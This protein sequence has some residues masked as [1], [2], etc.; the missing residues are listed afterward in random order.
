MEKLEQHLVA[1]STCE[2]EYIALAAAVQ[3]GKFLRQLLADL[4]CV[5]YESVYMR[6]DNQS[7]IAL[8]KNSVHHQRSKYIDVTYHLLSYCMYQL[9]IILQPCLLNL[10]FQGVNLTSCWVN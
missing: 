4:Q 9:V 2:A 7:A 10:L 1:L 6:A 8:A 3:E 5:D